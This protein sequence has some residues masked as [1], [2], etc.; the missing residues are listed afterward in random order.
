MLKDRGTDTHKIQ[1]GQRRQTGERVQCE[2]A[3]AVP[4]IRGREIKGFR[5]APVKYFY[6]APYAEGK[7][8]DWLLLEKIY[9]M[10]CRYL[11]RFRHMSASTGM[12]TW[13]SFYT[14]PIYRQRETIVACRIASPRS[15]A[16]M[17]LSDRTIHG[18]AFG[19]EINDARI[20]PTLLLLYLNSSDFWR[21]L[22]TTMPPM[23]TGRRSIRMSILKELLIPQQIAFPSKR[24]IEDAKI[25][26]RQ[27]VQILRKRNSDTAKSVFAELDSFI[28]RITS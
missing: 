9:P 24:D 16:R 1:H 17:D 26:E 2:R 12:D 28:E 15:F 3:L 14:P 10:P 4:V 6:L 7:L 13:Y 22:A 20:D 11:D 8:I 23:G 19:I 25:L 21:Q 27:I 18:S 5:Y